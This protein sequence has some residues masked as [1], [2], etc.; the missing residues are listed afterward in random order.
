[1][2]RILLVVLA[3]LVISAVG[4]Y[5][6]FAHDLSAARARLIGHSKIMDTSFGKLEYA[7]MGEGEPVLII[8]GA[9]GGFDQGLDITGTLASYGYRLIAPSRFGYLASTLPPN[10]TTAAQADAYAELLDSL[11]ID[12]AFVLGISAGAWSALQFAIRHP[13]HCRALVLIV[14]ANYLPP[15][16]SNYGGPIARLTFGSD[17]VAWG[18]SKLTQFVP[19]A[20]TEVMLGTKSSVMRTAEP[21]EK[22]RVQQ[23]LDH[24]LPVSARYRGMQFDIKTAAT[25]EP[26]PI[27]RITTPVLTISAEDDAFGTAARAKYVAA[28]VPDGRTVI[29]PT[30]GHALVGRQA[31]VLREVASFFGRSRSSL[32]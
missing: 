3:L 32:F 2:T 26:Y 23:V 25:P 15:N 1:M 17:F 6:V 14:P 18:A 21:K 8:H 16:K 11:G 13:E 31:E 4:I 27:E 24:L 20:M 19:G 12:K 28:N 10:P 9:G 7:L 5:A 29:Y 22:A 30:G